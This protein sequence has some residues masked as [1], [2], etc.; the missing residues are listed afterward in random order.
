MDF[1]GSDVSRG[2]PYRLVP[3]SLRKLEQQLSLYITH[4][5]NL[6]PQLKMKTKPQYHGPAQGINLVAEKIEVNFE[7]RYK[8]FTRYFAI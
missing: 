7:R 5:L 8:Q 1:A 6:S 2:L 3:L 4:C